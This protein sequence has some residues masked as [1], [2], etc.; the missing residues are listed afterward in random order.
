M[1]GAFDL[2]LELRGIIDV[3]GTTCSMLGTKTEIKMKKAESG[4]WSK[5]DIPRQVVEEKKDEAGMGQ[6][7]N[8]NN[9]STNGNVEDVV[10]ALELDD[11]DLTPQRYTL[12]KEAQTKKY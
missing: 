5:L 9:N 3:E 2:D 11:I 10:D 6:G 8:S 12:S 7:N 4:S 1:G